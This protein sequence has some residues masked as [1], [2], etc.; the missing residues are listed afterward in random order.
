MTDASPYIL[1]CLRGV[2]SPDLA[3]QAA[4]YSPMRQPPV[5][6]FAVSN[7]TLTTD[8]TDG[9][10]VLEFT[11]ARAFVTTETGSDSYNNAPGGYRI[12]FKPITG[13][14]LTALLAQKQNAN[15]KACWDFQFTSIS[16]AVTQP[17]TQY[18]R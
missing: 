18:C 5:T 3:G 11:S 7:M 9:Y 16:G 12:R 1:S 2:P 14:A 17:T 10:Q 6:P 8:D 13:D 4:K 15:K